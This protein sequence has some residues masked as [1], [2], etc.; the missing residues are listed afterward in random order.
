M[1]TFAIISSGNSYNKA[2]DETL[3]YG[4]FSYIQLECFNNNNEKFLFI[5]NIPYIDAEK[6]ARDY[7]QE[8][9][10]FGISED[11]KMQIAHYQINDK[12]YQRDKISTITNEKDIKDFFSKY[13]LDFKLNLDLFNDTSIPLDN[14]WCFDEELEESS[15]FKHRTI[16]RRKIKNNVDEKLVKYFN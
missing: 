3:K 15:T 10:F 12:T 1:E 14:E 6:I 8:N 2:G 11:N 5:F 7:K 13:N 16:E 9:F 4:A